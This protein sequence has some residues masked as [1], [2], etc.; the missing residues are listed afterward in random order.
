MKGGE[1]LQVPG[2]V[3]G[4]GRRPGRGVPPPPPTRADAVLGLQRRVGNRAL[5]DVLTAQREPDDKGD[6]G[7]SA[8]GADLVDQSAGVLPSTAKG[9]SGQQ[10]LALIDSLGLTGAMVRMLVA[11]GHH[12]PNALTN[13]A[14]WAAHPDLLGTKL[15][16]SQP[17]FTAL[18]AEWT[19][20]RQGLVATALRTPAATPATTVTA[21][22][23]TV[24]Q[25]ASGGDG[26]DPGFVVDQLRSTIDR[27]SE[28]DQKRFKSIKWGWA[29]YPGTQFPI[30]GMTPDEVERFQSDQSLTFSE[31]K[32]AFVGKHQEDA[33]ALFL[34]LAQKRPGGGERRVNANSTAIITADEFA[35]VPD[36]GAVDAYIVGQIDPTALPGAGATLNKHAAEA[37]RKMAEAA[38]A[39]GVPLKVL[40]GFRSRAREEATAKK[41]TNRYAFGGFSPH[42]LGLAADIAL[43]VGTSTNADFTETVTLMPKLVGILNSPAY[44]WVYM[45]GSKFGFYQYRA[46]PWHWEYNPERFKALFWSEAD[47][48]IQQQPFAQTAPV[49]SAR[50]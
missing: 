40:S 2:N 15:Q 42:S 1:V 43:K 47:P 48:A 37:F 8:P 27:L 44:K 46:E 30:K 11:T 14:F 18:A 23:T 39:D 41:S 50:P 9:G 17:G 20:L 4:P 32:Q 49:K 6:A 21:P 36:K 29:D 38:Q 12:D 13:L 7:S 24:G 45:N 28:E 34:A 3:R 10:L 5:C 25:P 22:T 16:P 26:D 19:G 35:A 31:K 33:L